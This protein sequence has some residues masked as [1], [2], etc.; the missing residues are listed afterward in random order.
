MHAEVEKYRSVMRD[1]RSLT[2]IIT[3]LSGVI[4]LLACRAAFQGSFVR[5]SSP[6]S[7]ARLT[8]PLLA[9]YA[10]GRDSGQPLDEARVAA[11]IEERDSYRRTKRF[12]EADSVR[13]EVGPQTSF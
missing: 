2:Q 6:A 4:A 1:L 11:L 5:S 3:M 9:L 10:R 8:Q 7:L 12:K 13:D